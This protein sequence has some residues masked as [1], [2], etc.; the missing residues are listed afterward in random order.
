MAFWHPS[1]PPLVLGPWVVR[2]GDPLAPGPD[3]WAR[4]AAHWPA[5]WAMVD[6]VSGGWTYY[7]ASGSGSRQ[8]LPDA[9]AAMDACDRKMGELEGLILLGPDE[10]L[11]KVKRA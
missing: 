4:Y 10:V 6:H 2:E 8:P 5:P 3:S 9:Q 11:V 1:T 7:T